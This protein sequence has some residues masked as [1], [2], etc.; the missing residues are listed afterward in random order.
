[1]DPQNNQGPNEGQDEQKPSVDMSQLTVEDSQGNK[2]NVQEEQGEETSD[3]VEGLPEGIESVEQ[4]IDRYNDLMSGD[5]E[6]TDDE[7]AGDEQDEGGETDEGSGD[8]DPEPDYA[9]RVRE[10][11]LKL[12][13]REIYD[14]V[15][16][17]DHYKEIQEWA[18]NNMP[19]DEHETFN[20][21]FDSSDLTAKRVA[22]RALQA[23]YRE[24]NGFEGERVNGESPSGVTPI[25]SDGE[26]MEAMQDP[27]YRRK[28][29]IG[30]AYRAEIDR[31]LTAGKTK[32]K[33]ADVDGWVNFN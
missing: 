29:S 33:S 25:R 10:L 3:K 26:L 21:V 4:L 30:E 28:D 5:Q 9:S 1:M 27:R 7:S 18:S 16:G 32:G 31:R 24:A 13:D 17:E 23:M 20:K 2:I 6:E 14:M 11:E 8:E 12:H 15:G 22:A 19:E